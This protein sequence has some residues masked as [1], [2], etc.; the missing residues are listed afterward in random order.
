MD[1][2]VKQ[3]MFTPLNL[4]CQTFHVYASNNMML[5]MLMSYKYRSALMQGHL[6]SGLLHIS[7]GIYFWCQRVNILTP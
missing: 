2:P 6:N 4:W 5:K 3:Q 1:Q 7:L